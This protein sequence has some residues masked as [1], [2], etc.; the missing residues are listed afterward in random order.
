MLVVI[1]SIQSPVPDPTITI[2][3]SLLENLEKMFPLYYKR[4]Y[5][6]NMFCIIGT[7]TTQ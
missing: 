6:T 1:I 4:G 3:S 7:S 2:I 5:I